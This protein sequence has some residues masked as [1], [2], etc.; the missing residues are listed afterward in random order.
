[1]TNEERKVLELA[2]QFIESNADSDSERELVATIK[3]ALAKPEQEP[4]G[5]WM[6]EFNDGAATLYEVPQESVFGRTYRNMPVYTTPPQRT[7]VG[8]NDEQMRKICGS[9]VAMREA[10]REAEAILKEGNT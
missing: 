6:G 3:E 9:V 2:L 7:W 4:I 8:L 10:V 1:M 5:Y